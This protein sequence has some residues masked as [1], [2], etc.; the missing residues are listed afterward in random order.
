MLQMLIEMF[1]MLA[2]LGICV[3]LSPFLVLLA[4]F[5]ILSPIILPILII[6]FI[7]DVLGV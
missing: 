6:A 3:I 7:V 5:I 4:V 2:G 1:F